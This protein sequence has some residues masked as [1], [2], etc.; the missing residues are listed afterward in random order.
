MRLGLLILRE[1]CQSYLG[2]EVTYRLAGDHFLLVEYG[3]KRL[4]IRLRFRA[5]ALMQWL[6]EN[7]LEGM[8]ELTPGIRSLQIH[9]DSQLLS[10]TDLISHLKFA[11]EALSKKIND[12]KVPSRIVHI[13][14]SW[15]DEA[16]HLAIEK[17]MQSVRKD[18]PWC[19]SNLEFIRRINGLKDIQAVKDIVFSANYLVMGL[20]DV[21]LGAPVA[22]P[23]DPRHRLVTTK[24]NPARTWT[25]E[26]SVGIGGSYLCVYG[27]EGP[28]GYQFVGRTLQMWNRYKQT[29]EFTNPWLLRFFD[30]IK[31][32]EVSGDE[33]KKIRQDFPQGRYPLKI[34]ESSFSLSEYNDF[35]ESESSN[36]DK[37]VSNREAAFETELAHWH[38][39]GQFNYEPPEEH[40]SETEISWPEE[41]TAVD[42]PVSGSVWKMLVKIGDK[43]KKGESLLILESM[44]MEI[45]IQAPCDGEVTHTFVKADKQVNAGQALIVIDEGEG[46]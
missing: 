9:Y 43:V 36:I 26:N 3:E 1:I 44:K 30:Q 46:Q 27:M 35:L 19:P 28:G 32:Y 23:I 31:F 21:Y 37:F 2:D 14:L 41:S 4:D 39:T 45:N 12:L 15:D 16:C 13:P 11:E 17:Y 7:T 5:H 10:V 8:Q 29:D 40:V 25:A 24:Y 42:S 20:G 34:E 22:T 38:K 33:L 6:Q 18:A